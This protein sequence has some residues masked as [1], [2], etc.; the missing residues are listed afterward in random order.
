[1]V[2][3]ECSKQALKRKN[4]C[5]QVQRMTLL[6]LFPTT[7]L[8]CLTQSEAG[9]QDLGNQG[10]LIILHEL[11]DVLEAGPAASTPATLVCPSMPY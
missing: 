2:S 1:M 4:E 8:Q 5:F 11:A 9:V 10:A 7:T 6:L 3:E